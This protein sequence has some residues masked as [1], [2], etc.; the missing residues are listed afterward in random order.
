V[1]G[2]GRIGTLVAQ[3]CHAFGMRLVAYDPFVA[4]ERAARLGVELVADVDEVLERADIVTIHLPKNPDTIGLLDADAPGP[5]KPTARLLNVARGGIVVEE[6]LAEAVRT[7][8]IA[9]AAVDVFTTEPATESPLF[10][11]TT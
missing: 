7:G 1:L 8:V 5:M 9:G 6:D 4:P 3:R 10:G 11:S 2:L